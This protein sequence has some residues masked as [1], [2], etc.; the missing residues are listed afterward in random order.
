MSWPGFT[1]GT[2]IFASQNRYVGR[3]R[4]SGMNDGIMLA[5][6]CTCTDPKCTWSRGPVPCRHREG[7]AAANRQPAIAN[8]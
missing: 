1:A 4:R 6:T 5:G 8:V 7:F 2:S 3:R